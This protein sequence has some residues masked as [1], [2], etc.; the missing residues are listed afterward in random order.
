MQIDIMQSEKKTWILLVVMAAFY[1]I[2]LGHV[3]LFDWDEI[4]FAESAREMIETNN[5]LSVQINFVPFWEKPPLFFWMQV[6]TMKIFG[7]NEFA[8]RLPNA[9]FGLVYLFT[10]YNIGTK[11]ESSKRFG[12]LWATIYFGSFLPHIYFRSGIIDPVFNFFIFLSV[13]HIYLGITS[14]KSFKKHTLF[15]GLFCGLSFLTKGPVGLLLVMMTVGVMTALYLVRKSENDRW[16]H[17]KKLKTSIF[18]LIKDIHVWYGLFLFA[19]GFLSLVTIWLGAEMYYHGFEI[20]AK[21]VQYQIELFTSPVAGHGQPFYYHF[22]VVLVGC[23][24]ASVFVLP[25]LFSSG[26]TQEIDFKLWMKVLFWVVLILFSL[27]TT[28]IV[29]YS[30]MCYLPLTYLAASYLFRLIESKRPLHTTWLLLYVLLG[31]LWTIFM[32]ALFYLLNHTELLLPLIDD[33]IVTKSLQVEQN[34][35]GFEVLIGMFFGIGYMASVWQFYKNKIS[36]AIYI[37]AFNIAITIVMI[38]LYVLPGIERYSQGLA[39]DFY[40]SLAGQDV[41]VETVGFKSYA[42][43]FYSKKRPQS[44]HEQIDRN[45][46]ITGTIDKDVYFVVKANNNELDGLNG[47]IKLKCEG[48]F[49][50]YKRQKSN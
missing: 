16:F 27:S 40:T 28:K 24:P 17:I 18:G 6:V 25:M 46:L 20:L 50:F 30:S 9:I 48:G 37:I 38:S 32:V 4:N 47:I 31:L 23:F 45:T 14:Q 19:A 1:F 15:A 44:G 21:F 3:H 41:Y 11:L 22:V 13:Y 42:H 2:G 35:S 7:V 5:Y 10:L 33:E 34:W 43:Y 29:H 39:I 36:N 12:L 49:C 26:Q 8:A